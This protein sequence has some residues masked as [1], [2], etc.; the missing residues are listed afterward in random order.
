MN[1]T[2]PRTSF[3]PLP[4]ESRRPPDRIRAHSMRLAIRQLLNDFVEAYNSM[5]PRR[6]RRFKPSFPDFSRDLSSTQ[7]TITN[8]AV[9]PIVDRLSARVTF[10]ARYKN[11]YKKGA[12]SGATNPTPTNLT[13]RVQRKGDAWILLD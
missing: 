6:V 9:G 10:T 5:D 7:L 8:V 12:M 13:W 1:S 4:R 3:G 2:R 11:T